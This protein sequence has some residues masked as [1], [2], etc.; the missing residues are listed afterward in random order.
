MLPL[1]VYDNV[2]EDAMDLAEKTDLT[3]QTSCT[4][5]RGTDQHLRTSCVL[6]TI[7]SDYIGVSV[8]R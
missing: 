1:L 5:V 2:A 6:A 8:C 4:F 7:H 3:Q